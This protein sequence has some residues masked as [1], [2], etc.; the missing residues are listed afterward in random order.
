M[1]GVFRRFFAER[2]VDPRAAALCEAR[3]KRNAAA[4]EYREARE[5]GDTRRMNT[6]HKSYRH[7]TTDV[8]RLEIGA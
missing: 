4:V 6:A 7:A 3:A 1:F 8:V 2:P 5:I